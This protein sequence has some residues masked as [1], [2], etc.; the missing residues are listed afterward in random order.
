[1]QWQLKILNFHGSCIYFQQLKATPLSR[2]KVAP[3]ISEKEAAPPYVV[4]YRYAFYREIHVVE[5]L[6]G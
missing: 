3:F 1:M 5:K 6:I 4:L 2:F